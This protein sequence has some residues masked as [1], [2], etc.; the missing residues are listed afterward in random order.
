M[1]AKTLDERHP[2]L[3]WA[4]GLV[5]LDFTGIAV[6][7]LFFCLSLTPSLLPRD[8]LFAGLIGGINAAI[9]YGIGVLLGKGLYRFALRRRAWWPPGK[10][11]LLGLKSVVVIG[12]I[13]A[14]IL[15]LIPAA[16]WQRQVSALM[17]MEGPATTGYL[18]TL[19]IAVAVAAGL[20]ATARLLRDIVRLL[21]R[22]FIRRW[23]LH[24]EVAQFIGTAIV[25]VLVVTLVN[26]VL[27]RGFLAG[28][29]RVFQPQNSTTR[30]GVSQPSEPERSGSPASFADWDSLGFQGRNFVATGPRAAELEEVNGAPAKEPI[31]VYA[32]LHTGDTDDQR[33]AVLLSELER[34]HAFDRKLLVIVPTTGTGWVNPV[35]ARALE[36]MYNGDTAMVG[37]QY[38]YLP[39][40]ISFM[41]DRE[42][43]MN[44]GRLM[45][46]AIHA[47]WEQLPPEHRPEL[48]LY[49]ES[50]G[51]M[52]GQGAFSWL[53]DI[54]RMGFSSVLWVGPPNASPLWRGLTV[55]R[56]PGTP[57]VRPRYDNG[58]TVR[59][60]EAA[61]AAEIAHD[62][63]PPWEGTRVLF[64]QHPSDPIVWW[65]TDLLFSEP[66]WL[67]EPPGGD[68]TASMRWYP[69]ITFWQVAADITNASSVPNGHGHNYGESV[70][71]GWAAVAPPPG[72]T[73]ED[74]ERI[75][76]ALDK[77]V[78]NDGPEY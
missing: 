46:D 74:T 27:Y 30:E 41:G 31:R 24:R 16:A 76:V 2:V 55:R 11:V 58:R 65:S 70:L 20:I 3:R 57:E 39:S 75:R 69:I 43:S 37:M 73:P 10:R 54:S 59:F 62:A 22:M 42:K 23:H 33:I 6:G 53:P 78:A 4:W 1:T 28:A 56:D 49:G 77:T 71:D 66:D 45:I 35:A 40:W 68:R 5:R 67:V 36:L 21:A 18:R 60:S 19:I 72:W 38:S 29:S 61:D 47:R 44:N 8:W 63:A 50:L 9:G 64:L 26:G 51:S 17:G 34:T 7:A 52:A 13:A 14:S 25:V 12:A 32:G 48:V 15:M